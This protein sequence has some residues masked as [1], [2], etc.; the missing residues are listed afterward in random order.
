MHTLEHM[1]TH[2]DIQICPILDSIAQKIRPC[3]MAHLLCDFVVIKRTIPDEFAGK[4]VKKIG[5]RYWVFGFGLNLNAK[6]FIIK[7]S[8]GKIFNFNFEEYRI[9]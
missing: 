7:Y 3:G 4:I 6:C 2:V 8:I 9:H 5:K 1:L